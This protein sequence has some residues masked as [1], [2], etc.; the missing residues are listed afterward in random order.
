V[1]PRTAIKDV[2]EPGEI[3]EF[4]DSLVLEGHIPG[5][6]VRQAI[7]ILPN[8]A[9][10]RIRQARLDFLGAIVCKVNRNRP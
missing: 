7:P 5:L 6:P 9:Y 1:A 10:A 2:A 8:G 3:L 4:R